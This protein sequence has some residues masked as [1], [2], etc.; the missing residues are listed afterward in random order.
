MTFKTVEE[1]ENWYAASSHVSVDFLHEHGRYGRP[2]DCGDEICTGWQMAHAE[3]EEVTLPS[4]VKVTIGM[5]APG[6]MP[7]EMQE[8]WDE[9]KRTG[10]GPGHPDF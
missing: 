6:E 9:L 8:Q 3:A 7:E 5:F 10:I 1:F 2:C 4:G